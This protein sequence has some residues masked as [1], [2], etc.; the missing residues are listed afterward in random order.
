MAAVL[1]LSGLPLGDL[2]VA[3][4]DA[5][6]PELLWRAWEAPPP[7]FAAAVALSLLVLRG[8]LR[9]RRRAPAHAGRDRLALAGAAVAIGTLALVSPLDAV[10]EEYLLSGHMLQH[11]LIGD[12]APALL[13][14]ALRGPLLLFVCPR[15]LLGRL[16]SIGP[17]PALGLWVS[18]TGAWHVPALYDY[19][20]EHRLAHDLEHAL[21]VGA[22]T[23]VWWQLLRGPLSRPWGVAGYAL[24]LFALGML[25]ANALV[26]SYRPLY[27]AYAAQDERLLGLSPLADQ[28]A[29]ALVMLA[30]QALTLG[31]L[32]LIVLR[33]HFR[34]EPRVAP[35]GRHP[36]AT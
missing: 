30:E 35:A 28:Q 17:L 5:I 11:V 2:V 12:L 8:W 23:L 36:F 13:L 10:G 21:F 18:V 34:S 14:V 16:P 33:R 1:S 9:L 4:G 15:P 6:S 32:A 7:V 3:H 27:P 29:A 19:A 22:G 26:L 24:A 31:T 25:L 20:L